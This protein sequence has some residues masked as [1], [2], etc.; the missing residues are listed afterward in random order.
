MWK[1]KN[2]KAFGPQFV[3]SKF[4]KKHRLWIMI[5]Q[6]IVLLVVLLIFLVL[7][8]KYLLPLLNCIDFIALSLSLA[9]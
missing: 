1:T 9:C 5:F 3:G 6:A 2:V 8:V 7:K 4:Q